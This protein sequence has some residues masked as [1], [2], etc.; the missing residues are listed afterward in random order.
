[1]FSKILVALDGSK[2][3]SQYLPVAIKYATY[4][5][6]TSGCQI[7]GLAPINEKSLPKSNGDQSKN[8]PP[9]ITSQVKR[10]IS[11]FKLSMAEHR[12]PAS[13]YQIKQVVG[14]P[15]QKIVRESMFC[16]L[17]VIGRKCHFPDQTQ[18]DNSP[19][20]L[21]YRSSRPIMFTPLQFR[22]IKSIVIGL[23]GTASSSRLMHVFKH[24]S[25]FK[26][27]AIHLVYTRWEVKT[28]HLEEYFDE[29]R[30]YIQSGGYDVE[31]VVKNKKF[32]NAILEVAEQK[33]ADLIAF[34]VREELYRDKIQFDQSIVHSI[35][36]TSKLPVFTAR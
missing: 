24:L 16:D 12:I 23:D 6:E 10:T 7:I 13:R 35:M 29:I 25:P 26:G 34:G 33:N 32:P 21:L 19:D 30:R 4:V 8:I 2:D 36:E 20:R 28:Y 17:V 15:F 31:L 14:D 11:E 9:H 3:G 22:P 1:M 18:E 5:A 27:A